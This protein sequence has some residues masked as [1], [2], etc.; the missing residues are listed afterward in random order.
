MFEYFAVAEPEAI[1]NVTGSR[2]QCSLEETTSVRCLATTKTNNQQPRA[3]GSPDI[4]GY[5]RACAR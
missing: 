5:P 3:P 2:L 4:T 1:T